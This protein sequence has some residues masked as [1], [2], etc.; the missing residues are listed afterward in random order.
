MQ[1]QILAVLDSINAM[2]ATHEGGAEFVALDGKTVYLRLTGH[3]N[4]CPHAIATIKGYIEAQFRAQIDP[5]IVV[6]AVR[7]GE[8]PPPFQA[9]SATDGDADHDFL[10]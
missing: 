8:L 2:L 6:E 1:D 5:E 7:E 10:S 9:P 3:C 4:G